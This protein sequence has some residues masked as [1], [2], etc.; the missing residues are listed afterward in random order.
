MKYPLY[1]HA[2]D[3]LRLPS[4]RPIDSVSISNLEADDLSAGDI[5]VRAEALLAQAVAAEAEGFHQLAANLRRAAELTKVPDEEILEIYEAL[6]PGRVTP[7]ALEA[8]AHQIEERY[9]A[10]L[11]AAFLREASIA[12][13]A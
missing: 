5:G 3:Q 8:L 6:R 12:N 2:R 11:N 10:S 13:R 4:D 7:E 1:E 9:G